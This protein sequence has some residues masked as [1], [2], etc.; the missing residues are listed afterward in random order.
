MTPAGRWI[1]TVSNL[2]VSKKHNQNSSSIN[3]YASPH[4]Y[5]HISNSSILVMARHVP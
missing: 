5:F 2:L 3:T 4:P 1:S